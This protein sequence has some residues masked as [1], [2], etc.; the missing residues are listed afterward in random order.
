[1]PDD[2]QQVKDGTELDINNIVQLKL[3]DWERCDW[4]DPAFDLGF[5]IGSYL[6]IWLDSLVVSKSIG[7]EEG[8]RLAM[9]P[10]EELQPSMTE[11]KMEAIVQHFSL[12]GIELELSYLNANSEDIY[13]P[14]DL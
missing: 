11:N 13:Q 3:I 4:G 2:W 14:L 10:L 8:L 6:V 7:I 5:L 12:M 9:T 1:M